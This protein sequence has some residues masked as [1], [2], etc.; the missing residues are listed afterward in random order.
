MQRGEPPSMKGI[1][2]Q[3]EYCKPNGPR[4]GFLKLGVLAVFP[5][6]VQKSG[7]GLAEDL[8]LDLR[9]WELAVPS[10]THH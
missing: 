8:Q 4:V 10:A 9:S 5:I 2:K 6:L 7:R 1:E 3:F